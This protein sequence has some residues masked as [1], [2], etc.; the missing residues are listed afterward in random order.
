MLTLETSSY[1]EDTKGV[2]CN[3]NAKSINE[4]KFVQDYCLLHFEFFILNEMILSCYK[5][6]RLHLIN[7]V[8]NFN[9]KDE[10]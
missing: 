1:A 5:L 2:Q 6:L 4:K 9:V 7:T 10:R 3:I 8:R